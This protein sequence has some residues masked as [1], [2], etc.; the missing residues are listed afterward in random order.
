M[1][2]HLITQGYP[3]IFDKDTPLNKFYL[4]ACLTTPAF[5]STK[6]FLPLIAA[7]PFSIMA[8]GLMLAAPIHD[9]G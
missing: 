7:F 4:A 2:Y 9:N 6:K 8:H 1:H 5:L 3:S